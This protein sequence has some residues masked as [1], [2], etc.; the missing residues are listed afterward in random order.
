M[1]TPYVADL[2]ANVGKLA[3]TGFRGLGAPFNAAGEYSG[4]PASLLAQ[5]AGR[6]NGGQPEESEP[7]L[8]QSDGYSQA[9]SSENSRGQ[10]APER[11]VNLM[12]SAPQLFKPYQS[13]FDKAPP[14]DSDAIFAIAERLA[15]DPNS[16]F[17]RDIWSRVSGAAGR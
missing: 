13:E 7:P 15:R 10:D 3:A 8:G 17:N 6:A 11:L 12:Y 5:T 16:R 1:S 14:G 4:I 2:G 9:Q